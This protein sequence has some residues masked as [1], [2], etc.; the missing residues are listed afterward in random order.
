MKKYKVTKIEEKKVGQ[1]TLPN[2]VFLLSES[3]NR[4]SESSNRIV[5]ALNCHVNPA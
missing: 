2:G 3:N 1:I 4:I 5:V